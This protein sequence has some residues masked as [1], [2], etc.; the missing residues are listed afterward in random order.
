M[1]VLTAC[2]LRA[3]VRQGDL[4]DEL[5]AA[6]FGDLIAGTAP[7]VYQEPATFFR[8]THPAYNLRRM[9]EVVFN[10]LADPRESGATLRLSTGSGLMRSHVS[11]GNSH[12]PAPSRH[13]RGYGEN[14]YAL[15][16]DV[17]VLRFRP[18]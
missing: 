3:E 18:G 13:G 14:A 9:V 8:N 2:T 16:R 12:P 15:D 17:G 6:S 11:A 10:R 1:G 5:F 7:P 4:R